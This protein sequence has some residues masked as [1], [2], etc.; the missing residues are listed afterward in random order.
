TYA[1]SKRTQVF[2]AYGSLDNDA[3]GSASFT[4]DLRPTAGGK[5]TLIASGIRHSF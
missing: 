4:I 1:L 5:S 2:A 3:Q